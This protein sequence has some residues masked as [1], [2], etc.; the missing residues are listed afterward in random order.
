MPQSEG[1]YVFTDIPAGT[2]LYSITRNGT[3]VKT[4]TVVV[5]GQDIKI[6]LDLTVGNELI[7]SG[8]KIHAEGSSLVVKSGIEMTAVT[9]YSTSGHLLRSVRMNSSEIRVD[10]IQRGIFIIKVSLQ[11]GKIETR[12]IRMK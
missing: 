12:K 9:V 11:G 8:V 10:N 4:G 5:N 7:E 1:D 2:Y 6:T 3:V